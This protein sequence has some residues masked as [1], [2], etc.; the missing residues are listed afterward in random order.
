MTLP[1][2]LILGAAKSG[3]S[4]LYAYLSQHPD[5]FMSPRKELRYF[6]Y[7]AAQN[8]PT[9]RTYF[10][11]S[12]KTI[13]EYQSHFSEVKHEKAIGEDSP[14]Y[15]YT[16]G[17]AEEIHRIIPA[18][19]LIAILRNPID[20]AYSAFLHAVRDWREPVPDFRAALALEEERIADGWGMLWHYKKAGLYCEQLTRFIRV[21]QPEQLKV[22]L[23]DDLVNDPLSLVQSLYRFLEVEHTF[24][25]DM[26]SR[27]NTTGY[28]K[29][30]LVYELLRRVLINQNPL[31]TLSRKILPEKWRKS[32]SYKLKMSNIQKVPMPPDIRSE[33]SGFYEQEIINLQ[34]LLHRDLSNWLN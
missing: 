3:T 29:S 22:V 1:N 30:K 5:V 32:V 19:R 14:M 21:F 12:V 2:F 8:T 25:P 16:Q 28:P 26:N 6:S 27:P 4:A 17:T 20:R 7:T 9:H 15:L 10:H 13:E 31:K 23:Y 33:L 18:V 11:Q 34:D 24:I